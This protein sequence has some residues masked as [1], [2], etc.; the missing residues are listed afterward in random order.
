M[1]GSRPSLLDRS[2]NVVSPD[3]IGLRVHAVRVVVR[4]RNH[5]N[6]VELGDYDN[7]VSAIPDMKNTDSSC[8]PI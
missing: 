1:R 2:Q 4:A 6:Q 8:R 3:F 5:G 7:F